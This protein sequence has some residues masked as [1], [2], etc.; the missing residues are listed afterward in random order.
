MRRL[1]L[2]LLLVLSLILNGIS[3]P[4]AMARMS[5]GEDGKAA[6]DPAA[7]EVAPAV[8]EH[9][10]HGHHVMTDMGPASS[11]AQGEAPAGDHDLPCCDGSA[12]ACGCVMPPALN[13]FT[14]PPTLLAHA[15]IV[16]VFPVAHA[17]PG[18]DS[19]P[20]RPPAA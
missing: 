6:P 12:C 10:H 16:F 4:F 15:R 7:L 5:H 19:P 20:F 11:A 2:H 17:V 1:A 8:I 14:R 9:A 18:H 13:I 3:A